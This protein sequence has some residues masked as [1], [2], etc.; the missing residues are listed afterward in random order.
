MALS[1]A[2]EVS[3]VVA[4]VQRQVS[5]AVVAVAS[6]V[7]AEAATAADSQLWRP[8][9]WLSEQNLHVL[10]AVSACGFRGGGRTPRQEERS[11]NG[12]KP[13]FRRSAPLVRPPAHWKPPC[14]SLNPKRRTLN[15]QD[16]R[17]GICNCRL[18]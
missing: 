17:D 9:R 13:Q 4:S 12:P 14:S 16:T 5:A 2:E 3:Q 8:D 11:W 7:A 15:A 18:R 10:W 6:T 1:V